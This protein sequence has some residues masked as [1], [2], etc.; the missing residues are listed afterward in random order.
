[1]SNI[2]EKRSELEKLKQKIRDISLEIECAEKRCQHNWTIN[3]YEETYH[4]GSIELSPI[5]ILSDGTSIT[6]KRRYE[7]AI[8][9]VWTRTCTKCGKQEETR[10]RYPTAFAPIW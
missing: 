5:V 1:M 3:S 9:K 7:T 6:E 10:K 4:T 2:F 8:R